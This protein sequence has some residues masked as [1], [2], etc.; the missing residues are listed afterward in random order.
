MIIAVFFNR[1]GEDCSILTL[2]IAKITIPH[3]FQLVPPEDCSHPHL[4]VLVQ[5]SGDVTC[6]WI[7]LAALSLS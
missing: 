3:N 1:K 6:F 5:V 7:S 4:K 2:F